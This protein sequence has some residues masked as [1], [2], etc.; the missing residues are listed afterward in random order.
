MSE[1]T[2]CNYCTLEFM[3]RRAKTRHA[4]VILESGKDEMR[5]WMSARYSDEDKPSA[6]FMVLTTHCVC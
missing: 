3:K 5:G 6:Y 2:R 1:R 4:E